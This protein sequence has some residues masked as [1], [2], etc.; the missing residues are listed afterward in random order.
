MHLAPE[1]RQALM[2]RNHRKFSLDRNHDSLVTCL[3]FRSL[4]VGE[5][6]LSLAAFGQLRAD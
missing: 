3:R 2:G 4:V 1:G 6:C 5:H